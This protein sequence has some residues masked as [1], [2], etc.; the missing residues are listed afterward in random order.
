MKIAIKVHLELYHMINC[1]GGSCCI[2][3]AFD[4]VYS[5]HGYFCQT[6]VA[7]EDQNPTKPLPF[8]TIPSGLYSCPLS[9][10]SYAH[11][12]TLSLIHSVFPSLEFFQSKIMQI[13]A[14]CPLIRINL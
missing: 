8:K 3:D 7:I 1:I 6:G 2:L 13:S 12:E 11:A 5:L 10:I 14:V 4:N 9:S